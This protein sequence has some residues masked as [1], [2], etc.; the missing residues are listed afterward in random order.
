MRLTLGL[1]TLA[2]G[3]FIPLFIARG[4]GQ[5]DFWWWLSANLVVLIGL[6]ALTDG[7]WRAS[8]QADIG[9]LP[10][11]IGAGLVAAAALYGAFY[12]GNH[13]ARLVFPFAAGG[14][15]DVYTFKSDASPLRIAL[16]MLLVIG[17]GE[18]LFWRAFLQRRLQ[19]ACGA[20]QGFLAAA[21]IYTLI[22][23][24]SGNLMLTLAAGVC[25]LFWGGLYLRT[26]SALVNVVSHTA[27]DLAIFVFWPVG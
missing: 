13:L 26:G 1:T 2:V 17:P 23:L 6:A 21:A 3:L 5:F 11:K 20:W 4:A 12:I 10:L 24:G 25:G 19:I 18:E 27:W 14:I 16:L 22:H 7:G 8:L 9:R 15:A